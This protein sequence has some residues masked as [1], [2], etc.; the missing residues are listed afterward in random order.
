MDELLTRLAQ[1]YDPTIDD[2]TQIAGST[3]D[4]RG[5]YALIGAWREESWRN[6]EQLR[7]ARAAGGVH[8]L[9][10]QA[11]LAQIEAT[12]KAGADAILAATLTTPESNAARNAYCEAHT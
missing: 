1:R 5:M 4:P 8:G 9:L 7:H 10:Y 3:M 11:K 12:A 6:A 2:G